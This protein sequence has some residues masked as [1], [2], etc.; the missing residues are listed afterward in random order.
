M[1]ADPSPESEDRPAGRENPPEA[2]LSIGEKLMLGQ[3]T[4][5]AELF[6]SLA[7]VSQLGLVVVGSVLIG[8]AAGFSVE[9]AAGLP[10]GAAM[11][12]GLLLGVVGGFYGAGR[13]LFRESRPPAVGPTPPRTTPSGAAQEKGR[14]A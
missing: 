8:L 10:Q 9:R 1:H 11:V 3:V 2:M 14:T 12:V 7:L 6:R 5:K 13:L 4:E